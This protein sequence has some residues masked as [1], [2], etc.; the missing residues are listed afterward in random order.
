MTM[1][2]DGVKAVEFSEHAFVPVSAAVLAEWGA[3]V[4]KI[5]RRDGDALRS[6]GHLPEFGFSY[7][8]QLFNRNK[9]GLALDVETPEGRAIFEQLVRE[10]DVYI[11][12]HLPRVQRR[13]R[14][15]PADIFAINPGI[16]YARGS[17]QG[18]RGRDA[19]AGGNDN[20]S[21]WS[22]SGVGYMLSDA[23]SETI[24]PQRGAIGDAPSGIALAAGI[25]AGL[26]HAR[27]TGSGVEVNASLFGAGMWTLGPDIT[28]S[29]IT[30]E[31]PA[32]GR[33]ANPSAGAG[34]G[35]GVVAGTAGGVAAP[36][37]GPLSGAYRTADGRQLALSM[38]NE[39]RYWPRACAALGLEDLVEKYTDPAE[40]SAH[41]AE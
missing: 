41:A 7:Y 17:G 24:I 12:N 11:T 30:G 10:A 28:L 23:D 20:I 32:R 18:Q 4:I 2:L 26:L 14:T 27:A 37:A 34:A 38:T 15:S 16:V 6:I 9:R 13:L 33:S 36:V 21:F 40:R 19:E 5:E 1:P 39:R 25:L 22:R 31:V 3:D 35:G 29:S 8:F